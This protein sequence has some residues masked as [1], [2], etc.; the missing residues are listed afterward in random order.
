MGNDYDLIML[1]KAIMIYVNA[2]LNVYMQDFHYYMLMP[3]LFVFKSY[4]TY[5]RAKYIVSF[6]LEPIK[7]RMQLVDDIN[8]RD[9]T[10]YETQL[11]DMLETFLGFL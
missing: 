9:E 7:W 11:N 8:D 4:R 1:Y 3:I 6:Y 10:V 2:Y 5:T